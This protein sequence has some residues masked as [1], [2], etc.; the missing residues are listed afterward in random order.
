MAWS[1]R[2]DMTID[3]RVSARLIKGQI[4]LAEVN[5]NDRD[6]LRVHYQGKTLR[7]HRRQFRSQAQLR[8]MYDKADVKARSKI[9]AIEQDLN[10]VIK[11]LN[12]LRE[13]RVQVQTDRTM[14]YREIVPIIVDQQ[15]VQIPYG[16]G[17]N[18][19][20]QLPNPQQQPVQQIIVPQY[21]FVDR[22]RPSTARR[23]MRDLDKEIGELSGIREQLRNSRQQVEDERITTSTQMDLLNARFL[24]FDPE[25]DDYLRE[26]YI[27]TRREA[28]LY[29]IQK[30]KP[31]LSIRAGTLVAARPNFRHSDRLLVSWQGR[32]YDSPRHHYQSRMDSERKHVAER[33]RL[34]RRDRILEDEIAYLLNR[35]GVLNKYVTELNIN[36]HVSNQSDYSLFRPGLP[37]HPR[38]YYQPTVLETDL[39][40]RRSRARETF[41]E[42]RDEL[43]AIAEALSHKRAELIAVRQQ[44]IEIENRQR[45]LFA[46]RP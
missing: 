36:V 15:R 29:D 38:T 33:N 31:V 12:D 3:G 26:T 11:Q 5:P 45:E 43:N 2:V 17:T 40:V 19:N 4:V 9:T 25:A 39:V 8:E 6:Y 21:N 13:V 44:V 22:L 20:G 32:T 34:M 24:K 27:V 30:K 16:R 28:I 7:A 46:A 41:G 18:V 1:D 42:W 14:Q 35:E 37:F 10:Q 23:I